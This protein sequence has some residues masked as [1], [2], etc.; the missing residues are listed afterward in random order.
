MS[1]YFSSIEWLYIDI[2]YALNKN[3]LTLNTSVDY[4]F[5][6]RKPPPRLPPPKEPPRLPPPKPPER[7]EPKDE[8]LEDEK[9]PPWLPPLKEPP[10]LLVPN[11]PLRDDEKE[12]PLLLECV[13]GGVLF[14]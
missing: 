10:R 8:R 1:I 5:Y 7:D 13:R 3:L 12:P 2:E 6:L 9:E 14:L 11:P 4:Y